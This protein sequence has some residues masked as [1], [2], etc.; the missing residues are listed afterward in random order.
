MLDLVFDIA[1]GMLEEFMLEALSESFRL[2]RQQK[3]APS[4]GV[5]GLI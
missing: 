3:D 5:L 2:R 4:K 1:F